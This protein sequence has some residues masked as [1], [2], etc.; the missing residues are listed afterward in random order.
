MGSVIPC[1]RSSLLSLIFEAVKLSSDK[2]HLGQNQRSRHSIRRTHQRAWRRLSDA[3][4]ETLA[5]NR[6]RSVAGGWKMRQWLGAASRSSRDRAATTGAQLVLRLLAVAPRTPPAGARARVLDEA[7]A[8]AG[9]TDGGSPRPR[10]GT[11]GGMATVRAPTVASRAA[12]GARVD[13]W[14]PEARRTTPRPALPWTARGGPPAWRGA[15][16][17]PRAAARAS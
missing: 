9:R 2:S 16:T 1:V 8:A 15:A 6:H 5:P 11:D 13:E 14:E 17:Q 10:G 4:R 12:R 7:A 3:E